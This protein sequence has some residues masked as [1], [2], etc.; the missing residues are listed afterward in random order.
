MNQQNLR[1]TPEDQVKGD[2]LQLG[3]YRHGQKG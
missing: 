1:L 3:S 2:G